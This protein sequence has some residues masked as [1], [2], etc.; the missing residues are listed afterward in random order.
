MMVPVPVRGMVG[1]VLVYETGP[2]LAGGMMDLV[3][4]S[5]MDLKNKNDIVTSSMFCGGDN[6]YELFLYNRAT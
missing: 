5:M 3:M 1:P 6:K 4:V 2:A